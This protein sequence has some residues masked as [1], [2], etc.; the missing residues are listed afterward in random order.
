VRALLPKIEVVANAEFTAA[1]ERV[2]VEH[3]TRITAVLKNGQ[4]VIGYAGGDAG[5][6]SQR[7]SDAEI[8]EKFRDLTGTALGTQCAD[9]ALSTLWRLERMPDVSAVPALFASVQT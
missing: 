3:R 4:R 6:L 2:P 9:A 8:E 5:D 7:K 1:Y